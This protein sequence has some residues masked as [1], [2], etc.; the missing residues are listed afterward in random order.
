MHQVFLQSI[1]IPNVASSSH[2]TGKKIHRSESAHFSD[3]ITHNAPKHKEL[4]AEG[5]TVKIN[6]LSRRFTSSFS[7]GGHFDII[8]SC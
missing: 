1:I 6:W 5:E 8:L 3:Y 7:E 4:K 2:S